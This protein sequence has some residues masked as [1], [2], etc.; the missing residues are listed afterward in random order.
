MI[1]LV[2]YA[3]HRADGE[4]EEGGVK[5]HGNPFADSLSHDDCHLSAL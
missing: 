3:Q 4:L 1:N 5:C 2:F